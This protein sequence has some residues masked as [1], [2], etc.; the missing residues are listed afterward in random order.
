M[1]INTQH[2]HGSKL[3]NKTKTIGTILKKESTMIT[4]SKRRSTKPKKP[5]TWSRKLNINSWALKPNKTSTLKEETKN[6]PN[7]KKIN[8]SAL[9]FTECPPPTMIRM[10]KPKTELF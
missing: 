4:L 9:V 6:I 2:G 7:G 8:S 5:K 3:K 1:K 10:T